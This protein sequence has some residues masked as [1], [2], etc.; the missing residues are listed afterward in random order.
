MTKYQRT[1]SAL[2]F[3][4]YAASLLAWGPSLSAA[5]L[6]TT[7]DSSIRQL[8][9]SIFEADLE[10]LSSIEIT[11]AKMMQKNPDDASA[12]YL[13]S[14][15]LLKMFT[16][17][18]GSYSLI[19]QS[20]ELAAQTYELNRRSELAI[21][22]LAMIL[23]T[24]GE[25]SRG[26][27]LIRDAGKKGIR[28]G[29]RSHLAKARLMF[30]GKNGSQ[31]LKL[32]EEVV[33][34]PDHSPAIVA[35]VLISA[36]NSAYQGDELINQLIA[37]RKKCGSLTLDLAV[38]NAN[39]LA[40]RFNEAFTEYSKILERHPTNPEALLSKGVIAFSQKKD[41]DLAIRLFQKAIEHSKL[42]SDRSAAETHLALTMI[43]SK[44]N[45]DATIESAI[46]AIKRAEEREPILM[47]VLTAFRKSNGVKPT[48]EFLTKLQEKVPGLHLAH[49][50]R[51]ELL[52]ERLGQ[53][54]DATRDFTNAITLDPSRSEYYNG[55]GLAWMGLANLEAALSDFEAAVA[56]NP[57]DASARYNIACAQ[58]RLGLKA[59]A[60][61]SLAK[62]FELDGRLLNHA[63]TDTDLVSLQTEPDFVSLL[64][65]EP[66]IFSV[67]H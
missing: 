4:F 65:S 60:I 48:I 21:A 40:M 22:S 66:R 34:D 57:E 63:K 50:L 45:L 38:A 42:E 39:A 33:K 17:D 59:A 30:D 1:Q 64:R 13:M 16:L 18:P 25:G 35:P 49:A 36:L 10:Q 46:T 56:T 44:K 24:S 67:A 27:D 37:W 9:E 5:P 8:E 54:V 3:Y 23:E 41:L 62:A 6:S 32:L 19:R 52:S 28:L 47:T 12:S 26:L 20:T 53:H 51:A 55:R 29:W 43:A 7:L 31:V 61:E 58:A 15:L 11:V 2:A 14:V